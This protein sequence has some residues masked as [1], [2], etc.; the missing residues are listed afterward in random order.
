[1]YIEILVGGEHFFYSAE[2]SR[3]YVIRSW[4]ISVSK[5]KSLQIDKNSAQDVP[6]RPSFSSQ[7][8]SPSEVNMQFQNVNNGNEFLRKQA[9]HFSWNI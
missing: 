1:M 6:D 2:M 8:S 9:K 7:L 4:H 3:D 5:L